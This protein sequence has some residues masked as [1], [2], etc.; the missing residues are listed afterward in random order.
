MNQ[1]V[2]KVFVDFWESN[3]LAP[4]EVKRAKMVCFDFYVIKLDI[5]RVMALMTQRETVKSRENSV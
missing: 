3:H 4:Y 5:V 2:S 1:M